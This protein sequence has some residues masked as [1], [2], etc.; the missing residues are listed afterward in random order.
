MRLKITAGLL[1][2]TAAL[3]AA[4][5]CE[6]G[7]TVNAATSD[8]FA[9]FTQIQE[10]DFLH[11]QTLNPEYWIPQAYNVTPQNSRGPCGKAAQLTNVV[12]NPLASEYDW[13]GP[14]DPGLQLWVRSTLLPISGTDEQMVPM[15]EIVT[16]RSDILYGSFR[17]GMKTTSVNGTC[18]AFFFYLNDTSEIDLEFLSMKPE[19]VNLVIQSPESTAENGYVT[20]GTPDFDNHSLSFMPGEGYH[21]YR[22]DWLPGQITF[23]VDGV[24]VRIIEDGVPD[25]AGRVHVSHW[26]NGN[27]G[28]SGGP[29]GADARVTVSYVKAYFNSSEDVGG[30]CVD[31][32]CCDSS[33]GCW[34][35][36]ANQGE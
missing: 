17:I 5:D 8:S 4:A 34:G 28:W 10:T 20:P 33:L 32:E 15:A 21:E 27:E 6:C 12:P 16:A 25:T 7:Y 19:I 1:T 26:S 22:F 13:G 9:L 31:G 18:G 2:T 11:V 24:V 30:G 35:V 23:L 3:A 29:P 14:N 36:L